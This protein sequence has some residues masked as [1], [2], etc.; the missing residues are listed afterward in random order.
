MLNLNC[1]TQ[2]T[3]HLHPN[4]KPAKGVF[5]L[6]GQSL[7]LA[8]Q[9][10]TSWCEIKDSQHKCFSQRIF[11]FRCWKTWKHSS[12]ITPQA[13]EIE[14]CEPFLSFNH[15]SLFFVGFE[16]YA[17]CSVKRTPAGTF[18]LLCGSERSRHQALCKNELLVDNTSQTCAEKRSLF[19]CNRCRR[20]H[21]GHQENLPVW[22]LRINFWKRLAGKIP[23]L[24]TRYLTIK[25]RYLTTKAKD[26]AAA[27]HHR[28]VGANRTS[29]GSGIKR[30]SCGA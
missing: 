22:T 7:M 11:S 6:C 4:S 16:H 24:W 20:W 14:V 15:W 9:K 19:I 23:N 29:S 28:E 3:H 2:L 27:V 13:K 26:V 17:L 25:A 5:G 30:R 10:I 18:S 12:E 1:Y 21:I 8:Q